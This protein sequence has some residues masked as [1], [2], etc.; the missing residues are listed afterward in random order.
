MSCED[1]CLTSCLCCSPLCC[2]HDSNDILLCEVELN[3]APPS[4]RLV[5]VLI[6]VLALV[7]VLDHDHLLVS[8]TTAGYPWAT[9]S[10]CAWGTFRKQQIRDSERWENI[11]VPP[12]TQKWGASDG[13][14]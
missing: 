8:L 4:L 11:A 2:G 13:L 1:I 12:P 7:L 9:D 3:L 14:K 5:L 10:L 6:Q